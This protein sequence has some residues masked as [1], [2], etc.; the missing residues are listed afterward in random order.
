M[1]AASLGVPELELRRMLVTSS[2]DEPGHLD[3]YGTRLLSRHIDKERRRVAPAALSLS[4][5]HRVA[6]SIG[7]LSYCAESWDLLIDR[8]PTCG[9]N[10]AWRTVREVHRCEACGFDLSKA[11]TAQ[12][13]PECRL[14]LKFVADLVSHDPD[15]RD[16][17]ASILPD[18]FRRLSPS[19]IFDLTLAFGTAARS[20]ADVERQRPG[21]NAHSYVDLLRGLACVCDYP[22]VLR[23]HVRADDHSN[24][25]RSVFFSRV[26]QVSQDWPNAELHAVLGKIEQEIEPI[27]HGVARLRYIREANNQL[28]LTQAAAELQVNNATL[29]QML[30]AGALP[31]AM[32]RGVMRRIRWFTSDDVETLRTLLE[33]RISATEASRRY[34]LP[35]SGVEQLVSLGALDLCKSPGVQ[36]AFGGLQLDARSLNNLVVLISDKLAYP[37]IDAPIQHTLS[38]VFNGV[39]GM[40]KPWGAVISAVVAGDFDTAFAWSRETPFSFRSLLVEPAFGHRLVAGAYPQL[41][42]LPRRAE[43]LGAPSDLTRGE[44][45]QHLNCYPRDVHWLIAHGRLPSRGQSIRR[46]ARAAVE[47]LGRKYISSREITWRW[48]ISPTLRDALPNLGVSRV[49]GPFWLRSEVTAHL[50]ARFPRGMP[51]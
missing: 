20:Y 9:H 49:L 23:D 17:A 14:P 13:P 24:Q 5:H 45:E 4:P 8:C 30:E 6:W 27:R 34:G 50:G 15:V 1:A 11:A 44:V 37:N 39:G 21:Q 42:A 31:R 43:V 29:R 25:R 10:L 35:Y 12:V 26:W 18:P 3:Y 22:A 38:D 47:E 19:T 46:F 48:R 28:T 16:R 32:E 41:L 51:L 7:S 33:A 2:A 36:D 40:E